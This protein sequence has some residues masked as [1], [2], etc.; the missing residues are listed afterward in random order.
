MLTAPWY[1]LPGA[2][3]GSW[4]VVLRLA[5]LVRVLMVT[6]GARRLVERLGSVAA[7][8]FGVVVI[9]ALIAY[10]AEHKTNPGFA[11][12]GDALW[13]GYVTLTTVGY[14][15]IVPK[16]TT[17]RFAGMLIMTTGAAVL[18]VLAGSLASFFR[19]DSG[20]ADTS[21]EGEVEGLAEGAAEGEDAAL[22][23]A[24]AQG[25]VPPPG[26]VGRGDRGPA[27]A[28]RDPDLPVGRRP[29]VGPSLPPPQCGSSPQGHGAIACRVCLLSPFTLL[30]RQQVGRQS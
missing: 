8:A 10:G 2:S 18:G 13:W 20:P 27:R 9:G 14:G 23:E 19:L 25:P 5:R 3:P 16:T 21:S 15:D 22:D 28:G 11:T 6:R 12:V 26:R 1:L 30:T 29:S 7:V 24:T 4:V 17:G